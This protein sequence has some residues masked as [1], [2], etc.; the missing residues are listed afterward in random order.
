[1]EN[2]TSKFNR[3]AKAVYQFFFI[4]QIQN[5]N[6]SFLAFSFRATNFKKKLAMTHLLLVRQW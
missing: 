5:G 3:L 2:F 6:R 1:M 4:R